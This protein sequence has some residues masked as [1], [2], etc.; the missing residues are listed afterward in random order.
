MPFQYVTAVAVAIPDRDP[1]SLPTQPVFPIVA[2]EH[3]AATIGLRLVDGR[4]FAAPD[5]DSGST[6]VVINR[7][8]AQSY[9][10]GESALGKCLIAGP[11]P[12]RTVV[13]IVS[14]TRQTRLQEERRSQ[15]YFPTIDDPKASAR[16]PRTLVVRTTRGLGIAKDVK[17]AIESANANLPFVQVQ[18]LD[19]IIAPKMRPWRL[20][21]RVFSLFGALALLLAAFGLYGTI[22]SAVAERTHEF[23]VRTALGASATNVAMLVLRQVLFVAAVGIAVGGAT[24][25]LLR[26]RVESLLFD[27]SARDIS[28]LTIAAATLV[29]TTVACY[30]PVRRAVRADPIRALRSE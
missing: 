8:L 10:P 5:Y 14:D 23:G 19:D 3:Y 27:Q 4:W 21:S 25:L 26:Q 12:C 22:S 9:W 20:G 11:G 30:M 29:C 28:T 7:T 2:S 13:G 15:L 6:N 16:L 24:T 17:S 1:N 18:P